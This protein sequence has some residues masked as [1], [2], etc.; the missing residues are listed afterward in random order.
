M[1]MQVYKTSDVFAENEGIPV[2]KENAN[3]IKNAHVHEFIELIYITRGEGIE[4]VGDVEYKVRAGDLL[5]VNFGAT[6]AFSLTDT[7]FVQILLRPE[8]VSEVLV[9]SENIFD[10]FALPQFSSIQG[11]FGCD[12]IVRFEGDELIGATALVETML[13]EYIQKKP[14]Y[15]TALHGYTQ[16]LFTRLIRKLKEKKSERSSITDKIEDYVVRH[17]CEKITLSDIASGCF[18][19]P[20]YFSRKFKS[21]FGKKLSCYIEEKR[22]KVAAEMLC[23]TEKTV[24]EVATNVGFSDK[25]RFYKDF[26]KYYGKTPG[27]FR[28]R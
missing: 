25:S 4:V 19:N 5:F 6:H 1:Q 24:D 16:V 10:V 13:D 11:D 18:Y 28:K 22:L 26:K 8:F 21:L 14:G 12:C 17:L 15:K 2:K 23:G 27:E 3:R 9:N 20:S 7:D